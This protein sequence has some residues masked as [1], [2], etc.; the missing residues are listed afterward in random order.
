MDSCIRVGKKFFIRFF[1]LLLLIPGPFIYSLYSAAG[2]Y[3]IGS[4]VMMV[5]FLY[6]AYVRV[7]YPLYFIDEGRLTYTGHLGHKISVGDLEHLEIEISSKMLVLINSDGD[8]H[9]I[10][11][12]SFFLFEW[13]EL[14]D[15]LK[16]SGAK[17]SWVMVN[18]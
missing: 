14:C 16:N 5:I 13:M 7:R 8:V 2:W 6:P 15:F 9:T 4:I 17:I 12:N 10:F 1:V 3:F 11:R 18:E